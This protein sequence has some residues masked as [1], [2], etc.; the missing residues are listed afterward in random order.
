MPVLVTSPIPPPSAH[1]PGHKDH[2]QKKGIKFKIQWPVSADESG[3]SGVSIVAQ[4]LTKPTGNHDG[5]GS[6][7]GLAQW[8][9]HPALP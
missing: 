4:W 6:I 2:S 3:E 1:A 9:R 7:P 5:A 8:V